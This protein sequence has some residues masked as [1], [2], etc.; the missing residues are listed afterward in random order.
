MRRAESVALGELDLCPEQFY[1]LTPGEFRA[2]YLGYVRRERRTMERMALLVAELN[3]PHL[4][5][6]PGAQK[7]LDRW[8]PKRATYAALS[9]ESYDSFRKAVDSTDPQF[10]ER[11]FASLM[12]KLR[13]RG[14]TGKGE[15]PKFTRAQLDSGL[16]DPKNN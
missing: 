2:K 11:K 15:T 8:L 10:R 13:S 9:A 1:R 7:Y 14:W 3:A 4:K 12:D 6:P 16:A 5:R